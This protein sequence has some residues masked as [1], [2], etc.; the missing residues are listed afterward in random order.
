MSETSGDVLSA[1]SSADHREV[2]PAPASRRQLARWLL[3]VGHPVLAPLGASTLA[4]LV[5]QLAG[6]ALFGLAMTAVLSWVDEHGHGL[7][8]FLRL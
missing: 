6:L 4:R 3:G 5:D 8:E 2:P 1:E 7:G